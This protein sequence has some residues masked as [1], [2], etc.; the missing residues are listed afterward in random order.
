MDIRY[1]TKDHAKTLKS[2]E[3]QD[4]SYIGGLLDEI[5]QVKST[6]NDHK[7]IR[8]DTKCECI[9]KID[10]LGKTLP[11]HRRDKRILHSHKGVLIRDR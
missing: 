3:N 6:P 8:E 5:D 11:K 2:R 1:Q 10:K 9:G 7:V 4:L